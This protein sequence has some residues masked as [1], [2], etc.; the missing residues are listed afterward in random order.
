VFLEEALPAALRA[1]AQANREL[2]RG[3]PRDYFEYMGVTHER[4]E[5]E[6]GTIVSRGACPGDGR[7]AG[8][9]MATI[10]SKWE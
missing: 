5:G 6:C 1:A 10:C 4:E 8:A 7:G 3:L 2:R 9:A